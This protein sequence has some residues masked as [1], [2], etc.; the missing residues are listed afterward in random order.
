MLP[1]GRSLL[2][3]HDLKRLNVLTNSLRPAMIAA[4][5]KECLDY[6]HSKLTCNSL[7]SPMLNSDTMIRSIYDFFFSCAAIKHPL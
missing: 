2:G 3:Y 6:I 1:S 5:R 7:R 4:A